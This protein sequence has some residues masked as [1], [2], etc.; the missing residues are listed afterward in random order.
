MYGIC[1][2]CCVTIQNPTNLSLNTQLYNPN[3]EYCP[4]IQFLKLW[5]VY[6]DCC[7]NT[8]PYNPNL[9]YT[10]LQS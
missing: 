10:N 2:N 5:C 4:I 7:D 8:Q 6:V 3:L 1:K 9:E